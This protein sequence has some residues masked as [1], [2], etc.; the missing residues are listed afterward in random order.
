MTEELTRAD[1]GGS[2]APPQI[3]PD[4]HFTDDVPEITVALVHL[5]T[6]YRRNK[7]SLV[8]S[9]R[10]R[11]SISFED[12]EDVVQE[13]FARALRQVQTKPISNLDA[14][15]R[16]VTYQIVADAHPKPSA[17]RKRR[18]RETLTDP[19][20]LP[21]RRWDRTEG[22]LPADWLEMKEEE[23]LAA[24]EIGGLSGKLRAVMAEHYD[25]APQE[26]IARLLG[27]SM[28]AVRQNLARA[29]KA[30]RQRDDSREKGTS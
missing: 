4:R 3:Y 25:G 11:N 26:E 20:E 5:E 18:V 19:T 8:F 7:A 15:F 21:D 9:V 10:S 22:T 23:R 14:W 30:L 17:H 28:A 12:A 24:E 29:R 13:A 6:F 2:E 1:A 27:M 16:K